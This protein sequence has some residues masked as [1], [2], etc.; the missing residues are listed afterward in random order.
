MDTVIPIIATVEEASELSWKVEEQLGTK[1]TDL[2]LS[3]TPTGSA[4]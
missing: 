3:V 4:N 2:M 1:V